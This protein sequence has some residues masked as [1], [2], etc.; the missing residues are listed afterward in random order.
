MTA[1][2]AASSPKTEPHSPWDL[3]EGD[4]DAAAGVA[5]RDEL[6]EEAGGDL[7]EGSVAHLVDHSCDVGIGR[8]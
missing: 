8:G 7:V 6:E 4:D 5:P 2:A 1:A 3:F